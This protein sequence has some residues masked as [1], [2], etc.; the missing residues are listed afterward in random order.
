MQ[1]VLKPADLNRIHGYIYKEV[2]RASRNME[3]PDAVQSTFANFMLAMN[4]SLTKLGVP[5]EDAHVFLSDILKGV[6]NA[7]DVTQN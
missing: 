3:T 6:T 2:R 7:K 4:L 1:H 5:K